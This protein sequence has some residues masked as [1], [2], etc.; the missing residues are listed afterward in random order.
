[1]LDFRIKRFKYDE[2]S[3]DE[4]ELIYT[5]LEYNILERIDYKED[6]LIKALKS[7]H[8]IMIFCKDYYYLGTYEFAPL[9][10]LLLWGSTE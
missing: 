6:N 3:E 8:E 1:M 5:V 9:I 7:E 10:K 2:L 4:R